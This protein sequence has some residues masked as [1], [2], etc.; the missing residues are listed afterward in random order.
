MEGEKERVTGRPAEQELLGASP[1]KVDAAESEGSYVVMRNGNAVVEF[2][3]TE[4]EHNEE[5]TAAV[6]FE[7][8]IT[9]PSAGKEIIFDCIAQF[10]EG[11]QKPELLLESIVVRKIG[12]TESEPFSPAF[13]QLEEDLAQSFFDYL[14]DHGVDDELARSIVAIAEQ[15]EEDV[16][17][18]WLADIK[19]VVDAKV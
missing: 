5:D 16:Y 6:P 8:I 18:K 13:N 14:Q 3:A 12:D 4:Y 2:E 19:A 9:K 11:E 17:Q 1:F 7:V 15:R 10:H